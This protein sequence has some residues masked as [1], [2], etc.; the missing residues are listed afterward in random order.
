LIIMALDIATSTGWAVYDPARPNA[1][2]CGAINLSVKGA[3]DMTA[4]EVRRLMRPKM[5][6]A[7]C[8]LIDQWRPDVACLEQPLNFIGSNEPTPKKAPLLAAVEQPAAQGKGKKKAKGGPNANTAFMLNQ[9]FAV[10]ET[11][12]SHKCDMVLEVAPTTW[13]TLTK[14]YPGDTKERSIAFC[15]AMRIQIPPSLNKVATGDAA[16]AVVIAIWAAGQVQKAQLAAKISAAEQAK[17][18]Q[19]ARA[20]A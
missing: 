17:R 2:A 12:C 6:E 5:D 9:L 7:V 10:A 8:G 11:V 4:V 3:Q 1:T 16:D 13:Q 14:A 15:R 20:A 19:E 18:E